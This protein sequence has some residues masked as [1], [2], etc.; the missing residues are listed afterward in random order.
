MGTVATATALLDCRRR[1]P[2]RRN[3]SF[4]DTQSRRGRNQ[5]WLHDITPIRTIMIKG[6]RRWRWWWWWCV[7]RHNI[8]ATDILYRLVTCNC[9]L[10]E[11]GGN[12]VEKSAM[13]TQFHHTRDELPEGPTEERP[14]FCVVVHPATDRT[15]RS[16]LCRGS[17]NFILLSFLSAL[18][19]S[20]LFA[21]KSKTHFARG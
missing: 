3:S 21:L 8:T 18:Q 4:S 14:L 11:A 10:R 5:N 9:H 7:C 16:R 20:F 1:R 15:R 19:T 13:F 6:S 12:L 17:L 2:R